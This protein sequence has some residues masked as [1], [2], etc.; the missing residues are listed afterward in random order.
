MRPG[1]DRLSQI[2][3][4]PTDPPFVNDSCGIAGIYDCPTERHTIE[5]W[6]SMQPRHALFDAST[7][8][9]TCFTKNGTKSRRKAKEGIAT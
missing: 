8:E 5:V 9:T 1:R 4:C 7:L 6:G 3:Q 2:Q